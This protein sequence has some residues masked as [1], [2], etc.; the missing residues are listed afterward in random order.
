MA[1][2]LIDVAFSDAAGWSRWDDDMMSYVESSHCSRWLR[3]CPT[4]REREA[5]ASVG[6]L[7]RTTGKMGVDDGLAERDIAEGVLTRGK[8]RASRC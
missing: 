1:G 8:R 5:A 2:R 4:T 3:L 6:I 7:A